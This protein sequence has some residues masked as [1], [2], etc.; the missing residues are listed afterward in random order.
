MYQLIHGAAGILI[1]SQ[2]GNPWLAFICGIISHFLLDAIPHDAKDIKDWQDGGDFKKKVALEANIDLFLFLVLFFILIKS[3]LVIPDMS[4]A[5]GIV[6]AL[7]PD[8]IWGTQELFNIRSKFLEKYKFFH[9]KIHKLFYKSIYI[10]LQ[11]TF[12]IQFV[13]L[14]IFIILIA[15]L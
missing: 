4:I 13:L 2:T 15:K 8:Y 3:N 10:P 14:T 11:L 6:G 5:A 9:T 12:F 7:L 1:G